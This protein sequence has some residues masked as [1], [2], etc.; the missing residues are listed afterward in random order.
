MKYDI[1]KPIEMRIADLKYKARICR[2]EGQWDD[3]DRYET[4]VEELIDVIWMIKN[5]EE[6][7]LL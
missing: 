7:G 6:G 2:R 3:S 1:K 5:L 4:A